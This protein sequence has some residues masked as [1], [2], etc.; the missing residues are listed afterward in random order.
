MWTSRLCSRS[1]INLFSFQSYLFFYDN[2]LR[3]NKD[4][5]DDKS[6]HKHLRCYPLI[7]SYLFGRMFA[8]KAR[9]MKWVELFRSKWN[10]I[11]DHL[12]SFLTIFL[13]IRVFFFC[14]SL[15]Q[16][17][18]LFVS[19]IIT[20]II[21]EFIIE[22]LISIV[23]NYEYQFSQIFPMVFDLRLTNSMTLFLIIF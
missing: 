3:E 2:G 23:A 18:F 6:Y 4:D 13:S 8:R 14:T 20:K 21:L 12:P 11:A 22:L 5:D 17:I 19:P 1:M 9:Q 10:A 15:S 7:D 16:S